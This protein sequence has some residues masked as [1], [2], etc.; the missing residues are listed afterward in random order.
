MQI[1][2]NHINIPKE[3]LNTVVNENL[4]VIRKNCRRKRFISIVGKS[5]A[6]V[7]VIAAVTGLCMTNPVMAEKLTRL[8]E[9]FGLTQ[10]E[11]RY[12]GDYAE[13]SV[14]LSGTNVCESN[15]IT[16][17]L[18]EFVCTTESLTVSVRIESAEGFP[19]GFINNLRSPDA[20]DPGVHLYLETTQKDNASD[21]AAEAF[22]A[23][24]LELT[25]DLLDNNTI[26]GM[27][28]IDFNLYPY[29]S[30]EIPE[31]FQW[32]LQI[33]NIFNP[34]GLGK[35][36]LDFALP[37]EWT[38]SNQITKQK[39]ISS[40]TIE[41]NDYAPNGEGISTVTVTP[42]EVTVNYDYNKSAVQPDAPAIGSICIL[43]A[44][45]KYIPDKIGLFSPEGFNIASIT[46]YYMP[47]PEDETSTEITD[48]IQSLRQA[49]EA[50]GGTQLREYV[51]GACIYKIEI[52]LN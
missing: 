22:D 26:A 15:G 2:L 36:G 4:A 7:A 46:A 44:N 30:Y 18:S 39:E 40:K 38:F 34:A 17:T 24:F 31:T 16:I 27:V 43:D 6:A 12:P 32:D 20:T 13:N 29:N 37:G 42:Y 28:R 1:N 48:R 51:E 41:V 50:D 23:N 35:T 33:Y 47:A 49:D 25:G 45:G 10:D 5:A 14:P 52:P 19:E 9:I 11:Q 8:G 3:K 21:S